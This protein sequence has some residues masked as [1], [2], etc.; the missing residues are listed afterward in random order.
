MNKKMIMTVAMRTGI[1]RRMGNGMG[2]GMGVGMDSVRVGGP[3]GRDM[4]SDLIARQS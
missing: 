3:G 4:S 1:R 2:I